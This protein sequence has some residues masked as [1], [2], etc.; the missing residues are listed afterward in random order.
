MGS[1]YKVWVQ[2]ERIGEGDDIE[3]IGEEEDIAEFDNE[4][5]AV[6]FS[7]WLEGAEAECELLTAEIA[8]Q[9]EIGADL[10]R[11]YEAEKAE[12]AKLR[13]NLDAIHG[14]VSGK[15]WSPDTL[16][17]IADILVGAG[18][19]IAPPDDLAE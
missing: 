8:R 14:V 2:V 3:N 7:G 12:I 13:E 18:Y 1:K 16:D 4:A 11:S 17:Q 10:L 15:V 6:L 19:T 9:K 5:D